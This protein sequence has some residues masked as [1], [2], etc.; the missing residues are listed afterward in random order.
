MDRQVPRAM[1]C[2]VLLLASAVVAGAQGFTGGVRGEVRDQNGVIPGVTVTLVNEATNISREVVTNAVGQYNFPAV[3]PGTYTLKTQLTGYK[4]YESKGLIVGTQQFITLDVVLQVGALEESITVTGQSPLI[5]TSTAST[6][7]VLDKEALES[8]PA[9]GRNAFLIGVTVPT[10]MP[11]GDPQ[12][13]RQ[14]DQTNASRVSMG[15]GGIRANNY[16][17]DGIPISELRG[18]AVLNP[19]MEAVEEVKVQV[20]TYDAEMGRTGGG[21][22]N[23]TMRSGTNNYH[24]S[25]FYQTRPVWGQSQ[26]FFNSTAGLSKEQTGE[27]TVYYRLYGGGAGGPIKKDRTFFWAATEGYRSGTT[28]N[29][30]EVWPTANQRNGDFSHTT[31]NG[32][33][34]VLFNP[35][36]RSGVAS[37][38][39]P[40]TG[41]GSIATGGLFTN[42][43][44]PLTHPAVSQV[45]LNIM[46]LWPTDTIQ[47]PMA[48]N[49]N[50]EAN[51]IGTANVVD[52]A[53]MFTGKVE[54]KITQNFSLTGSYIYNRTNEPGSTIMQADK[55]FMADQDQ[56]F[57]PLR[58]RPHVLTV[59]ATDVL[60]D[61]TVLTMRYGFSTWQDSCDKQAFTPG[62]Q[63]LGFAPSYVNALG[64]GGSD[65]FPSLY[66]DQGTE[67]VGGW[68]GYPT[69]W[70]SPVTINATV[71]HLKGSHSYK[72]G[73]DFRRMGVALDNTVALGP[74]GEPALGGSFQ[75]NSL[76]T[77]R[78]GAG[79]HEL[80]SLLL[81]L[82]YAGDVPATPGAGEW[83]LNYWGGYAQDDWRVNSNLTV[84]YGVRIEREDGLRE[85]NDQQ[86]VAFDRTAINPID[87][88][89]PKTGLLAGQTLRGGLIYAGVNGANTYQGDPPRAKVAPRVGMTYAVNKDT[90][91]RAG[92]G[93]FYAP[94]NFSGSHHGQ[95]GYSRTTA[96]VQNPSETSVPLTV[97]D[98]PFPTI[99]QPTGS[100]LGLLTGVGG[101][102]EFV[103]QTKGAPKVHQY[104][105]DVQRELPGNMAVTLGYVGASGRDIGYAGTAESTAI[106]INQIDPAVARARFP[107]PNGSWDA[108]ALRTLV[109]NPFFG[110]PAAGELG[111]SSTIQQGQLLRPFP[112][113][114]DINMIET[115]AGGR[116]QY[117]AMTATLDK[118][119][120]STGW[121]GRLSYTFSKTMD[122]QFGQDNVYQTRTATPQNN[123]DLDAEYSVSNFDS[124]HRIILAPI[125][126]FPS[127]AARG[128]AK[129]L[130]LGGWTASAVVELVSGA[131]LNSVLSQGVSDANLGLFGGRQRPNLIGDP[132]TS[133]SDEDRV[134][135]ALHPD[136]RFFTAA[137]FANPGAGVYGNAP[138]T[139]GDARYQFRK[140][141]DLV[142]AKQTQFA[143]NQSGEIRF[144][145]LNLTNTPKFNGIDSNQINN[146]AFG[147]ITTQAGFMQIW[148][149]SFRYRF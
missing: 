24:G 121:G 144:E 47:G 149:L 79:G 57:G 30:Q 96:L 23:V 78:N 137:A 41:T 32:A 33:P 134:S 43:I 146:Q 17:L 132:N 12:F 7:G 106:N 22:F 87:T 80:A 3:A 140:N 9:P 77:G 95:I 44:I 98:N 92:Y 66:F 37:A 38:R 60:N 65:T 85:I 148:Q 112:E 28:R 101:N 138:R 16:L 64:P 118:R 107:G 105:V 19:T 74:N 110:I 55:L 1:L 97:L 83:Y 89:V 117:N 114:G 39:C 124:P 50:G 116:R 29:Q 18:R 4:T 68:G 136:A 126:V 11:T 142:I 133:G 141:V 25:G 109:P 69:R 8:L 70:K 119:T 100:S 34:V 84:N 31:V 131:P 76:F 123:Y 145:F 54:H 143:G 13:N 56:W 125:Y 62:L 94:W 90:V 111:A 93:L 59:N 104:S 46:K 35:W 2:A 6:G 122:N 61:R 45:G 71:T 15:G 130:L 5:D 127:P 91:V 48:Q 88:Q 82:P 20:H 14:Q 26:N 115:T 135:D 72:F 58:R 113:F 42:G 86:T 120:G 51:A 21:V 52:M 53:D 49:E 129:H 10:V 102:I 36:C 63:S 139:D 67:A 128:S 27:D 147:R 73:G 75:F 99:Q 103:D 40:A 81:G 108:A